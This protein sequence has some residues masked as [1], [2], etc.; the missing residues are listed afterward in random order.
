[1]K[2]QKFLNENIK[3]QESDKYPI[4]GLK[5]VKTHYNNYK[6]DVMFTFYNFIED[7]E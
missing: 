7:T 4:I 1:M 3:L 5:N 6:G 2:I